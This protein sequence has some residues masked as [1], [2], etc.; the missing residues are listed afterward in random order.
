MHYATQHEYA[1]TAVDFIARR[2]RLSFLNAGAALDVLPRVI[3][4]MGDDLGWDSKRRRAEWTKARDF[5]VS[6]GLPEQA[7]GEIDAVKGE[8]GETPIISFAWAYT[9]PGLRHLFGSAASKTPLTPRGLHH[10]RSLFSVGDLERVKKEFADRESISRGEVK[11][12]LEDMHLFDEMEDANTVV[13]GAF[14]DMGIK[15]GERIGFEQF[16][17][18]RCPLAPQSCLALTKNASDAL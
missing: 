3:Q 13:E 4:L 15:Q 10:S 16:W 11:S 8:L 14:Y 5:L 1:Q 6:M 2:S 9:W 7:D 18:V 17:Q 12:L